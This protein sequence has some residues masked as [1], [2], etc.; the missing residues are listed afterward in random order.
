MTQM[1][2]SIHPGRFPFD[3]PRWGRLLAVNVVLGAVLGWLLLHPLTMVVYSFEHQADSDGAS[4]LW[5][6]LTQSSLAFSP[7]MLVMSVFFAL[8]GGAA[9]LAFASFHRLLFVRERALG[10]FKN[11]SVGDLPSLIA[12]GENEH[13]EFKRSVRWDVKSQCVNRALEQPVTRAIAGFLNH[14]GG[15][16]VI[17]V[18]DNGEIIG[19]EQDYRTLNRQ[20]RD[21]FEQF[22]VSLVKRHL[23]GDLCPLVHVAFGQLEG[24]D[25]CRLVMEPSSRPVYLRNGRETT[26]FVRMGNSTRALDVREAIEYS[27]RR[28]PSLE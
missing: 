15:S 28:W 20:D 25:V 12:A 11:L 22:I 18:A 26:M 3:S 8:I 17:G 27:K 2:R 24:Q 9:G 1:F 5:R 7:P 10:I 6:I 23:G 13:V 19:L 21:G 4:G 16:L 14:Q